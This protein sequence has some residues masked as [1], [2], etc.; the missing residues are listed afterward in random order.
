MTQQNGIKIWKFA[1]IV[2]V[3]AIILFALASLWQVPAS[4]SQGGEINQSSHDENG[5]RAQANREKSYVTDDQLAY[6][7]LYYT[8]QLSV[9]DRTSHTLIDTIDL[10]QYGCSGP[11]RIKI[12]PVQNQ[13]YILC[14]NSSNL[15]ILNVPDLS[16][17]Y[18]LNYPGGG[19]DDVDFNEDGSLAL[20]GARY[21]HMI[22]VFDTIAQAIIDQI[23]LGDCQITNLENNHMMNLMYGIGGNCPSGKIWVIDMDTLEISDTIDFG[24]ILEGVVLSP[25]GHWLYVS[26]NSSAGIAIIDTDINEIVSVIPDA[27]Q[28]TGLAISPDGNTLYAGTAFSSSVLVFDIPSQTNV[29]NIPIGGY[30]VRYITMDCNGDELYVGNFGDILSV[31]N[32]QNN[33]VEFQIPAPGGTNVVAIFPTC[34]YKITAAKTVDKPIAHPN[35]VLNYSITASTGITDT[36]DSVMITD[37]LPASLTYEEGSLS[38]SSGSWGYETGVITWT[39]SISPSQAVTVTFAAR[40]DPETSPGSKITNTAFIKAEGF[41]YQVDASTEVVNYQPQIDVDP[42]SLQTT[43]VIGSVTTQTMTIYNTGEMT[44]TYDIYEGTFPG[45]VL[46]LN[47]DEPQGSTTF[48]DI[49]GYGN[50]A[51]CS[52]DACPVAG[53]PG[54]V[55]TALNF[56][57]VDDSIQIPHNAAFDQIEDQDK[58]S[59]T[60]WVNSSSW[61]FMIMDQ[62][63]ADWDSGWEFFIGY[64]WTENYAMLFKPHDNYEIIC[65][66][67]FNKAQW[68]HVAVTYDRSIGTIQF[69][70]DGNQVCN[71]NNTEDIM[72]TYTSPMYIGYSPSGEDEHT[73]G[74][75]DEFYVFDRA[76]SSDEIT[77][78]YEGSLSGDVPWLSVDPIS[79]TVPTNGSSPVEVTFDGNALSP[80]MYTAT[81]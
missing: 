40:I 70:V 67:N 43:Q 1:C 18:V 47:L 13:M 53:V 22:Y 81:L 16:L 63:L 56:D 45:N 65:E 58:V 51:T 75:I 80:G 64:I 35:E 48:Y 52:G 74:L 26:D 27:S 69:Y 25:D 77:A 15:I 34:E 37:T 66:Y 30:L 68:Y 73:T 29:A 38:A 59:I 10:A 39:G 54:A 62:Y 14:Q 78:L 60:A 4:A 6:V 42:E 21:G 50:N 44:L 2:G 46:S 17:S 57:G 8:N 28:L 41:T 12:N 31:V 55:G 9:I 5:A 79:G 72:D 3:T 20:I 7:T 24:S 33:T 49:S 36:F 71:Y 32:T 76:L 23:P 19:D 61:P 11:D